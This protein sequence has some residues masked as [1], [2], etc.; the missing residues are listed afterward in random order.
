MT[1]RLPN[2]ILLGAQKSG[3]TAVYDWLSQH[4]DIFGNPAMKDFPFFCDPRYYERGP[5]WFA[6]HFRGQ[7]AESYILHG[8]VHYLFLGSEIAQ[9][10]HKFNP[11][12][13]LIVLLRNPVERAFSGWLQACKTGHETDSVFASALQPDR[14]DQL[15]SLHDRVYRSYLSHGLYGKQLQQYLRVFPR[16]QIHIE[17][18]ESVQQN[19]AALCERLFTFL[20]IDH[21]FRPRLSEKNVY[22]KPRFAAIEKLIQRGIP[23]ALLHKLIPLTVRSKL[24]QRARALNTVAVAKPALDPTTRSELQSYYATDVALLQ[25]LTGLDLQHWLRPAPA[26]ELPPAP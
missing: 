21:G 24:R 25:E 16:E 20:G 19:P 15:H 8:Y 6:E 17:L 9:R 14:N 13:R 22:G 4:P 11:E 10:L 12:L 1:V 23:S 7:H 2:L 26:G 18:Y 5:D 3:S